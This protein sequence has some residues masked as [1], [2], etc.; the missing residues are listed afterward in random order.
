MFGKR[1]RTAV[2]DFT[3]DKL[4][5]NRYEV[6]IDVLKV[7]WNNILFL[8]LL[9]LLL[10]LPLLLTRYYHLLVTTE[11]YHQIQTEI[12]DSKTG[13]T[14]ILGFNNFINLLYLPF[15]VLIAL[16]LS[17]V[18][19]ILK[20]ILWGEYTSIRSDFVSG[21]REN[22]VHL[23]LLLIVIGSFNYAVNY[24]R[25]VAF[26]SETQNNITAFLPEV[27]FITIIL[28]VACYFLSLTVIYREKFLKKIKIGLKLY[29]MTLPKTLGII[30]LC[31]FPLALLW[32]NYSLLQLIFPLI[33]VVFYLP[34]ALIVWF[35]YTCSVFDRFINRSSFPEIVDKGIWRQRL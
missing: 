30:L 14:K 10:A 27:V 20:R 33:Y 26:Y 16:G 13:M 32:I 2:T 8:G 1:R 31:I 34:L 22:G 17:G 5:K 28:P 35:L 18:M 19:R 29:L 24:L 3:A 4:P 9:L 7:R 23:S 12:I 6:F 21:I 15:L 11:I 25:S